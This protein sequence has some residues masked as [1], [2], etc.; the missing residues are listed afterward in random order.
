MGQG[1]RASYGDTETQGRPCP[2]IPHRG[3]WGWDRVG[4]G[5]PLA[6][7]FSERRRCEKTVGEGGWAVFGDFNASDVLTARL[8]AGPQLACPRHWHRCSPQSDTNLCRT[9]GAG[10]RSPAPTGP[11]GSKVGPT[12]QLKGAPATRNVVLGMGPRTPDQQEACPPGLRSS[13]E[14]TGQTSKLDSVSGDDRCQGR[15]RMGL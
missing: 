7:S 3:V 12:W 6:S 8:P 11:D 1:V 14:E 15:E 9:G 2:Y 5:P 10:T 13:A 4:Q